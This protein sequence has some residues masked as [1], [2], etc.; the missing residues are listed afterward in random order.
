MRVV[1]L[2]GALLTIALGSILACADASAQTFPDRP[3]TLIVPFSPGGATDVVLRTLARSTEKHLSRPV[4]IEN[5]PGAAATLGPAQMTATAK[6]D[7]YTIAQIA[8]TVFRLPF[9]HKTSYDPTTDFTYIIGVAGYTYG[10]VVRNDAPWKSFQEFLADAR[11]NP[12]KIDYGTSGF[13]STTHI[14]MEQIAKQAGIK[15]VHVPFKGAADGVNALL[16]GHIQ[17]QADTT[18]WAPQVNAGELR[19]LVTFGAERTK[20]WPNVPTLKEL[21]FD[22]VANSSWG[23]AGPKGMDPKVVKTLHDAFKLGMEEPEFVSLMEDL[24][25]EKVYLSSEDYRQAALRQVVEQKK[26]VEEF[27]LAEK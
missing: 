5:R 20:H 2:S 9:M 10:L 18:T 4:I 16:G 25:Q 3:I 24:D 12:D 15:F 17:A 21:G 23:L 14:T 7:G 1:S 27:G 8:L 6:P 26:I 22:I 19:L 11:K 13:G